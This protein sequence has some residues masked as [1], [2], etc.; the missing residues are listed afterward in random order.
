MKTN[1]I[2]TRVLALVLCMIM[3]VGIMTACYQPSK[4]DEVVGGI[5]EEGS[6]D[7]FITVIKPGTVTKPTVTDPNHIYAG[8]TELA[9]NSLILG[10][11]TNDVVIGDEEG[12]AALI[13]ADVKVDVGATSLALSI[14]N[15]ED[16]GADFGDAE[17]LNN[18]D[19]HISGVALDNKTPMTVKLGAILPI[20]LA[21]TELKLYHH[22]NGEAVLMTRV[23]SASDFAI[24]NQYVYNEETGEV[25]IYVASFSTFSMV[26]AEVDVLTA[27]TAADTSWYTANTEADEFT[28]DSA[29]DFIGFRNLVDAGTTFEGKTVKLGVDIDLNNINFDPIGY[30]YTY[31]KD[32][33]TAFMG[34][35][36]G[37][38]H[39][40]YNLY[41]QGWDLESATGKD[42]TYSTAG[43]G[44][45][46]SIENATIKN[47]G[48]KAQTS[49]WNALIWV[50]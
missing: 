4:N 24:H 15:V 36:D 27:E 31:N 47:L 49:K 5:T 46:A 34:T 11:L 23:N 9:D 35:F 10:T 22:E 25:T 1:S 20:G 19:V 6:T 13:P 48:V 14:K 44:L 8:S 18:L 37:Q 29:A 3:V 16:N 38:G 42:Y 30:G 45:F 7:D 2:F 41:E 32:S 50:S 28:L 21:N 26:K 40:I 39:T 12:I 33:N 43:A 17:I